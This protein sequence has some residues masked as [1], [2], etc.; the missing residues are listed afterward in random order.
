MVSFG[1]SETFYIRNN[2]IGKGIIAVEQDPEVLVKKKNLE[3]GIGINMVKSLRYWLECLNLV[4]LNE[5][6]HYITDF[7]LIIKENDIAISKLFSKLL[8]HEKLV[9]NKSGSTVFHWYFNYGKR[10]YATKEEMVADLQYWLISNDQKPYSES[11]L[12][13]DIDCLLNT[14][15]AKSK[16]DPE[17]NLFSI[18]STLNLIAISDY[19]IEKNKIDLKKEVYDFICYSLYSEGDAGE[20]IQKSLLE[21]TEGENSLSKILNLEKIEMIRFIRKFEVLKKVKLVNF[22]STYVLEYKNENSDTYVVKCIEE[23]K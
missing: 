9:K 22:E 2:W 11:T 21:I 1:K 7:G 8:L 4:C 12:K 3:L 5:T 16:D 10:T 23:S 6:K 20:K 13:K 17:D 15:T 14:Y 18:L 19:S